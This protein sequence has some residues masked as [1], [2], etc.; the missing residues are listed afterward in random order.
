MS[1]EFSPR[2]YAAP[3]SPAEEDD[4]PPMPPLTVLRRT[5]GTYQPRPILGTFFRET[6]FTVE[7]YYRHLI[8]EG[9]GIQTKTLFNPSQM[10]VHHKLDP[11]ARLEAEEY[12]N[13]VYQYNLIQRNKNYLLLLADGTIYL[14]TDIIPAKLPNDQFF[15]TFNVQMLWTNRGLPAYQTTEESIHRRNIIKMVE[16]EPAIEKLKAQRHA[17]LQRTI[18][19]LSARHNLPRELEDMI[20]KYGRKRRS[21]RSKRSKSRRRKSRR[22]YM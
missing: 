14:V 19:Q 22:H 2:I 11:E 13:I 6:G 5:M 17:M 9:D 8:T 1:S 21:K 20:G 15:E 16:V 10:L 18:A 4:L 12:N 3:T 7:E